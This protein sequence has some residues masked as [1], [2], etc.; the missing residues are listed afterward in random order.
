MSNLVYVAR[1]T[2]IVWSDTTGDLVMTLNDLDAGVARIGA[3]KDFGAGS[4]AEWFSW[5]LTVQFAT[6]PVVDETIDIYVSTSDG[7][8]E[9]G[10][11]GVADSDLGTTASLKNMHFVG[12]LVVTTTDATHDMT[13]S[14]VVRIPTRYVCPVIHNTTADNLK[15]TNDTSEFTLTAIPPE[16]Q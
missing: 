9:D 3:Q 8:E 16:I 7:S 2:P 5:R 4:K 1:E 15:A 11:E 6:A 12:S 13:A 14:G 10:Q